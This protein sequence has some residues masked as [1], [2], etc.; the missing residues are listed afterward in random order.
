MRKQDVSK[1][2]TGRRMLYLKK[3]FPV[4]IKVLRS[5]LFASIEFYFYFK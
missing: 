2:T 4:A 5:K 1:K 3:T